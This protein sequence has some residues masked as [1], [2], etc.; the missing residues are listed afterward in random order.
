MVASDEAHDG[1]RW[2][3][4]GLRRAFVFSVAFHLL[5][6]GTAEI[7]GRLGWWRHSLIRNWLVTPMSERQASALAQNRAQAETPKQPDTPLLFLEVDPNLAAAD[8]PEKAT[9]YAANNTR[10]ANPNP[11]K[12]QP[13]PKIEGA[14]EKVAR[15]TSV[16]KPVPQ[17]AKPLQPAEPAPP[18]PQAQP[19]PPKPLVAAAPPKEPTQPR[20]ETP[21]P[22]ETALKPGEMLV[23]KP[24]PEARS[25][26]GRQEVRSADPS[27]PRRERPR[28]LAQARAQAPDQAPPTSGSIGEKMKMEGGVSR[29]GVESTLD[30]RA[31][32]YGAY[33]AAVIAAIQQRWY[34]LLDERGFSLERSGKVVVDFR[35]KHDGSVHDLKVVEADVGDILTIVCQKAIMDPSPFGAWPRQMRIELGD[36]RDVRF[37]FHY[38]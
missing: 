1:L 36:N 27:Q 31:T 7:G 15:T 13:T 17:Q 19:Q 3:S 25:T 21:T 32:S 2:M 16:A 23:A 10:A 24:A 34:S 8:A 30:A 33:D 22:S 9:Y 20:S 35:M 29:F 5:A 28:T 26:D 12:S 14:Q 18:Q 37:T 11:A 38:N 6:F 4:N